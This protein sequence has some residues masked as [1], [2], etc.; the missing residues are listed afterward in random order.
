VGAVERVG[1][2][3]DPKSGTKKVYVILDNP[4]GQLEIGMAGALEPAK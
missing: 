1:K 3:L 2:L 4:D